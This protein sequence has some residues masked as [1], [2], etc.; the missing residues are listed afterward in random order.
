MRYTLPWPGT[1]VLFARACAAAKP[2]H[3]LLSVSQSSKGA[4]FWHPTCTIATLYVFSLSS[5]LRLN[6]TD[7]TMEDAAE[8]FEQYLGHNADDHFLSDTCLSSSWLLH[9]PLQLVQSGSLTMWIWTLTLGIPPFREMLS[10]LVC[11][12]APC[13]D[14]SAL[15]MFP[16]KRRFTAALPRQVVQ[17]KLNRRGLGCS[18]G[19]ASVHGL[20]AAG[21]VNAKCSVPSCHMPPYSQKFSLP[22]F[23]HQQTQLI[24]HGAIEFSMEWRLPDVAPVTPPFWSPGG[25]QVT[26]PEL[27]FSGPSDSTWIVSSSCACYATWSKCIAGAVATTISTTPNTTRKQKESTEAAFCATQTKECSTISETCKPASATCSCWSMPRIKLLS[28]F[29]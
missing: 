16:Y 23:I 29:K 25:A 19:D 2:K 17:W 5:T 14:K 7:C 20:W 6:G 9:C 10:V 28:E 3:H 26:P 4:H 1:F 13:Y 8:A 21:L 27:F 12:T 18:P 24:P 15:P 11:Q 22:M